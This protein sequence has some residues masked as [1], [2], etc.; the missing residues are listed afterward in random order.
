MDRMVLGEEHR[1]ILNT[2]ARAGTAARRTLAWETV[3]RPRH[4]CLQAVPGPAK[5]GRLAIPTGAYHA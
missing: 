2:A 5:R 4:A 1:T 3:S